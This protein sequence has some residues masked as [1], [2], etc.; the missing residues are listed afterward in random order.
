MLRK[1]S[2]KGLITKLDELVS[3]IV[4]LQEKE[5]VI[6]HSK[7]KLG[8][9]HLFSRKN[10]SL[11]WDIRPN[12]NSHTNC[13]GCNFR[14]SSRDSYPYFNWYITKFGKDKFDELHAEWVGVSIIKQF[15]L[16]LLR[17]NLRVVLEQMQNEENK[18][19]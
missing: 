7:E 5:C 4:R 19:Y 3:K 2:R 12:G 6:C 15:Q 14:H 18:T 9:S 17:D 11:R 13:W 1:P 8:N 16:E 10:L